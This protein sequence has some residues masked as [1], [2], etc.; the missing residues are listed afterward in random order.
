MATSPD[1]RHL[2]SAS[3]DQTVCVWDP[4]RDLPV[5]SLFFAGDDWIAWTP[6]GYYAASPGGEQLMGWHVNNG[7]EAMASYYPASQFRKTLYRPDVIKRL[8][9]AVSLDKALADADGRTAG[10]RNR[11]RRDPTAQGGHHFARPRPK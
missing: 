4:D 5:L 10:T 1:G 11:G 3:S 9:K 8:L 2:L 7:L 6:E